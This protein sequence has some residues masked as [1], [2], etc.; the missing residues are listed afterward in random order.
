VKL[1]CVTY[2]YI[3]DPLGYPD[4]MNWSLA[5]E[6]AIRA[7]M[8]EVIDSLLDRLVPARLDGLEFWYPHTW[9][10]NLTPVLA[11]EI[12]RRLAARNMVCCACAGSPGNPKKDPYGSEERF[13]TA[14]LLQAPVIAGDV[15]S[16]ALPEL[17]RLGARYRVRV[18]YENHPEQDAAQILEVIQG[19]SEWIGVALDTGSLVEHGG[20]PVQAIRQL[21][22]RIMHVH[23]RDVPAVG[24]DAS[25]AVGTGIVDV[26]AVMREL[27][28][29]GYDGWLSIEIP[30]TDHDPTAEIVATAVTIRLLW[31]Q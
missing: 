3:A 7:P 21:G 27:R 29:S 22:E 13:Q 14:C 30:T 6:T 9:P 8:L 12:R 23:L 4:Q 11:S 26:P 18:A 24:S 5:S 16:E 25:V 19:G 15:A 2:S 31:N 17:E 20:D 28:K 10:A 1:S